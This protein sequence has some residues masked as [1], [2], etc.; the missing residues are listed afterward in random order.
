[1]IQAIV[2]DFDGTI[3][4]TELP[5]YVSWQEAYQEHNCELP[6]NLW[7]KAVGS[8][9]ADFDPYAYLEEQLGR[10]VDRH[11]LREKRRARLHALVAQQSVR[12]GVLDTIAAAQR[13]GLRL[14]IASSS[15]REWVE[16]YLDLLELR[17]HFEAVFTREDVA[18][19]K[20]DP[21]LY[22]LAVAALGVQPDAA[23]AIEDSRNG[24]LAAKAAGL[25][26]IV[27]PNE[28][29][30]QLSFSEADLQMRSLAE[31]PLEEWLAELQTTRPGQRAL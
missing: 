23:V 6:L 15:S 4:E 17:E 2:F 18:Q 29:T 3:L 9:D 13:M 5:D 22:I 31:R 14:A 25:H 21:T 24:M 12:P 26:C 16:R 27:V 8:S 7:L 30:Q 20:P 11:I 1:M 28:V 10:A 19:V